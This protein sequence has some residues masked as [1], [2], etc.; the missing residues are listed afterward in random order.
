MNFTISP[1]NLI[2]ALSLAME[3]S[4]GNI[5]R[6][7]WRTAMICS[8]IAE[9]IGVKES[10]RQVLIFSALLH[11]I[12]A[13]SRWE[14]KKQLRQFEF[15]TSQL[16]AHA[17]VGYFLLQD[18]TQLGMLAEPI[19]HHHDAW[20]GSV[21]LGLAGAKIPLASRIINLADRLE[22]Q[23]Q[24]NTYIFEQRQAILSKLRRFSGITFDPELVLAL[25]EISK[26]ESFWL[27]LTNPSYYQNFFR[28][29]DEFGR[30]RFSIDD[31][32][33]IAEVFATIIDR[34]SRFTASHSRTVAKVAA[35]IAKIRGYCADEIKMMRIAGLLH[36]LGKL[37][38]PN[39]I[40]EKPGRLTD[41]EYSIVK[42]HS[43]Y[44]YRILEQIDNFSVIA[45][46]AAYHHEALDG[47]GY[48]FRINANSLQMGA[49]II[50]VAD[51]FSALTECRPYRSGMSLELV[52]KVMRGMAANRK[53]DAGIVNDLFGHI[54]LVYDN[55]AKIKVVG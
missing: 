24:D 18:S 49:R 6:H 31:V 41:K 34:T 13:A 53:L 17:E 54:E 2:R 11:D 3:L 33:D 7:H 23:I 15:S 37:A 44:T 22:I 36:D 4:C 43:Y 8:R 55:C 50:A 25:G 51:V 12:G 39:E 21:P 45:Q 28:E 52:E 16:Y 46:W 29:M 20:D 9:H 48:P 35:E 42:Q 19:R 10:E 14:E 40:L 1:I 27:D 26:Q 30:V 38:V 5:S 47:A 32:Y